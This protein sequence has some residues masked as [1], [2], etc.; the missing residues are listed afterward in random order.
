M[1]PL[2]EYGILKERF[3]A[4]L[5]DALR[6]SLLEQHGYDVQILE[7]ID[8]E[9]TP[10]NLLIRAVKREGTEV[11]TKERK[12][13]EEKAA[14]YEILCDAMDSHATLEKLLSRMNG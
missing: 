6:G 8:M 13:R 1:K 4:L 10:K 3:A 11:R 5:T 14:E 9:H 2:F 12:K 7:F